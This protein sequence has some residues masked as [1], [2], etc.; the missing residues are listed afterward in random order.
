MGARVAIVIACLAATC[1]WGFAEEGRYVESPEAFRAV[2][3]KAMPDL[4]QGK[5][6]EVLRKVA[7]DG[8]VDAIDSE[9][10]TKFEPFRALCGTPV[11]W[12]YAGVRKRGETLRQFVYVC[13]YDQYPM[14]WRLTAK[15]T[16]GQW[17]LL[18]YQFD[19]NLARVLSEGSSNVPHSDAPYVGLGDKIVDSV[20]HGRS[21]AVET[22]KANA[23]QQDAASL[24][25]YRRGVE[26][27]MAAVLI[28]GSVVKCEAVETASVGGVLALRS[29]VVQYARGTMKINF[30]FYRP[31]DT[32][33][34]LGW[35]FFSVGNADDLFAGAPLESSPPP[36]AQHTARAPQAVEGENAKRQ[37]H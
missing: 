19:S 29:Y 7:P 5:T 8:M 21:D 15:E 26:Q 9:L 6:S 27:V 31:G 35:R 25:S 17:S 34:V 32:W 30:M 36:A 28:N 33:K 3:D 11:D 1:Q 13:R 22:I 2:C 23:V 20:V 4:L 16:K 37:P 18:T 10:R 12:V 14:V 24:E